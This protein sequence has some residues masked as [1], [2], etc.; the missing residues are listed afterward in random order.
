MIEVLVHA[1]VRTIRALTAVALG[2][3]LG[4]PG[5]ASATTLQEMFDG[6]NFTRNALMF[7]DFTPVLSNSLPSGSALAA[8]AATNPQSL[9][10][11]PLFDFSP[12]AIFSHGWG[13]ATAAN[14]DNIGLDI[15]TNDPGTAGIDPG[16]RL[17]GNG[18]WSVDAS[19][20]TSI[21]S[22]QLSAYAYT[23]A[24]AAQPINS[25]SIAQSVGVSEVGPDVFS[26]APFSLPDLA[27]GFALQF[28][29]APD[30]TLLAT[31]LTLDGGVRSAA[32]V[33]Q[34][35][36]LDALLGQ[37]DSYQS[38]L[39]LF[40]SQDQLDVLN[41]V[42]LGISQ[43]GQL[44]A[45]SAF[46]DQAGIRVV[47]VI[48][49]GATSEGRFSLDTVTQRIDPPGGAGV[50]GVA[51]VPEPATLVLMGMGL[52]G[53]GVWRRRRPGWAAVSPW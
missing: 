8:A 38:L 19:N 16:F 9:L 15:L 11:I 43:Q 50:P 18:E 40:L 45:W 6:S 33:M 36:Q 48:G 22:A 27:G 29:L 34:F 47:N 24:T 13:N 7:S 5:A 44:D 51:A 37:L 41:L 28:V 30:N 46:S 49:V 17:N 1:K 53:I 3:S 2:V 12:A 23:V 39:P 4:V 25:A 32:G 10:N 31:N 21:A 42:L 52:A 26:L 35:D 20:P 14:A